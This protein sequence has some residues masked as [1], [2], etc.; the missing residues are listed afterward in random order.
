MSVRD[1]AYEESKQRC[2]HCLLRAVENTISINEAVFDKFLSILSQDV[3]MEEL[4][5]KLKETKGE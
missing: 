1:E 5:T 2:C 4:C 3:A